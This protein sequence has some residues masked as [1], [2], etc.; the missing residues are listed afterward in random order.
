MRGGS[1]LITTLLVFA[2]VYCYRVELMQWVAKASEE[3][4]M[5]DTS[6]R[7]RSEA[8][9]IEMKKAG[10]KAFGEKVTI[11]ELPRDHHRSY[12]TVI[13]PYIP[14]GVSIP[15]LTSPRQRFK[16]CLPTRKKEFLLE[17][18]EKHFQSLPPGEESS[19]L[20]L[21]KP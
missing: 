9:L 17:K 11:V 14:D 12:A 16:A 2:L 5:T 13:M 15:F 7:L 4:G 3:V 8:Q 10:E 18:I 20:E 1:F 6:S 21:L 19:F